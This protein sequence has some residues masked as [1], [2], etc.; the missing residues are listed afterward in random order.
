[1]RKCHLSAVL[2]LLLFI[3]RTNSQNYSAALLP[4]SLIE[5][6]HCV[7]REFSDEIELKSLKDKNEKLT[8]TITV[9]DKDGDKNASLAVLY[10]RNS[11]IK[12]KQIT[13][14]DSKGKK[15]RKVKKSEI[16]DVPAY[17]SFLL[18]SDCRMKLF[19]PDYAEYP[20]SIEYI[21]EIKSINDI[22]YKCWQPLNDY[23]LSIEHAKLTIRYPKKIEIQSKQIG[24]F[25]KASVTEDGVVGEIW[26][27]DNARA[28]E[29][30]PFA[31]SLS[32]RIPGI[33]LMPKELIYDDYKGKTTN[34]REYGKWF[35]DLFKGRDELPN[36]LKSKIATLISAVPDTVEQMKTLYTFMQ[37]NTRYVGIQLG[38]GHYQPF[39]VKTV[40]ET[41]Y[42]DCKDLSNYMY[43]LLKYIGIGSYPALVSSG[44]Y[45]EP[46]IKDFPN[47]HQ[48]DH[49][50]L[51]IPFHKDTLWL[52]CTNQKMPFGFLGDFTDDREALLITENGG[53]FAHT[54]KYTAQDN[55]RNSYS[56]FTIDTGGTALCS[57][58][59]NYAGLRYDEIFELLC[60][61]EEEQ[62]KWLYQATKLP[63]L[64]ITN[65][66]INN[67]RQI[68]LAT[69]NE[70]SISRHY[71]S[72]SGNYMLV[73]L[74][75]IDAQQPIQKM[76]KKRYSDVLIERSFT[77]QDTAVFKVPSSYKVESV[78]EGKTI[79]SKYGDYSFSVTVNGNKITYMRKIVIRQGRYK[80]SE[81]TD[82]QEFVLLL[83]KADGIKIMLTKI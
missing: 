26:G 18:Y 75:M 3:M 83:S 62:K 19:K 80:P 77:D 45:S 16:Q 60:L 34:W 46:I 57:T 44:R 66:S 23:A 54:K 14:F 59:T 68:P 31:V 38:I 25:K 22:S 61:N 28:I 13:F 48:F 47:F 40:F 58:I 36:T 32:E 72:F 7:I 76:L 10:D 8:K 24:I 63:A 55:S 5:N 29:D 70:S 42:G 17:E 53:K 51:C 27:L 20:Y 56:Y 41:G 21:Y 65:F 11:S 39:D 73:P 64:E 6:A 35:Y 37:N 49:L 52:E 82:F 78:P 4:D 15:I 43:S 79:H 9:L 30:E 2:G 69:V 71:C 67:N 50:I 1:M 33:Y 81:Y 12:I 74:N